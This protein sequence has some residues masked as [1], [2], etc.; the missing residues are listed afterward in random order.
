LPKFLELSINSVFPKISV[1]RFPVSGGNKQEI[2]IHSARISGKA[3][4]LLKV[5][6]MHS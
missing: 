3:G 6:G 2:R 1:G 4:N 5:P